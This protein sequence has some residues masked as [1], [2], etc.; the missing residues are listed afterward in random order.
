MNN[1]YDNKLNSHHHSILWNI[2]SLDSISFLCTV[3]KVYQSTPLRNRKNTQPTK[4]T[5]G[6]VDENSMLI[7]KIVI[8]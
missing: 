1:W 5:K 3:S 8:I 4:V 7:V 6:A 2:D